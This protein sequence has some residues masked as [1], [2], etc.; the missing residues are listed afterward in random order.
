MLQDPQL[1]LYEAGK[2]AE[3]FYKLGN[4]KPEFK[5]LGTKVIQFL[6]IE[7]TQRNLFN[8]NAVLE[9]FFSPNSA[10]QNSVSQD[11]LRG[12]IWDCMLKSFLQVSHHP[13]AIS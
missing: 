7:R 6:V 11:V 2:V 13:I 1:Q 9:R 3:K 5:G 4:Q 8:L 10:R 12:R